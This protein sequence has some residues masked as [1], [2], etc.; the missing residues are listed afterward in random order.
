MMRNY[1][2]YCTELYH[3]SNSGECMGVNGEALQL[4]AVY[5]KP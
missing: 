2:H 4:R 5:K 1:D 3:M